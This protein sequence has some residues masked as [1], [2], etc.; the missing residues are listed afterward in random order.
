M[1]LFG[2]PNIR[3]LRD[4]RDTSG[5]LKAL[6]YAKDRNI[7]N[8]AVEA[9][10]DLRESSAVEPL[11]ER[12]DND[13][14]GSQEV[15]I[16]ALASIGDERAVSPLIARIRRQRAS[17]S[18]AEISALRKI[19]LP[20]VKPL[21]HLLKDK[22]GDTKDHIAIITLLEEIGGEEVITGIRN[23]LPQVNPSLIPGM[24]ETLGRMGDKRSIAPLVSLLKSDPGA[25]WA[26]N[27]QKILNG[28]GWNPGNPEE[29]AAVALTER[30][31]DRLV[32]LGEPA[33]QLLLPLLRTGR[34]A[35]IIRSVEILGNIGDER[36]VEPIAA[37]LDSKRFE[38]VSASL[39]ALGMIG[40]DSSA[41]PLIQIMIDS[42]SSD[43]AEEARKALH[44]IGKP[45]VQPFINR[46][47]S[48]DPF[49]RKTAVRMLGEIGDRDALHPLIASRDDP[50][51]E[52]ELTD[53]LEK[54]GW[55][56]PEQ[57][58]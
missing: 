40:G 44:S 24:A 52:P 53:A 4:R 21:L 23:L 3:K 10:G 13:S 51:L 37:L 46:L 28:L 18:T 9:L 15:I 50:T 32:S 42:N 56:D 1:P 54:L 12:L 31:W 25:S 39:K 16:Q 8:Q 14:Y 48:S 58:T 33:V 17:F 20:A 57:G 7:R 26:P 6:D 2:K 49:E 27:V 30:N 34:S 29:E 19:G 43:A 38:I 22:V 47:N 45:A 36:C 55:I 5:L 35:E 11:L 41:E